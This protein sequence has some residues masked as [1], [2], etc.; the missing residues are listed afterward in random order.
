M[1]N[2]LAIHFNPFIKLINCR[3]WGLEQGRCQRRCIYYIT[4]DPGNPLACKSLFFQFCGI[5]LEY[6]IQKLGDLFLV[7]PSD[8]FF[9][10]CDKTDFNFPSPEPCLA[11]VWKTE[12]WALGASS[13]CDRG[14]DTFL[15]VS[16]SFQE[17]Y[18]VLAICY[19]NLTKWGRESLAKLS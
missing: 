4:W 10:L 3:K 14:K 19:E 18:W 16:F 11:L 7:G 13:C 2:K 1:E 12:V 17:C 9:V 8:F 15:L 5:A 6:R